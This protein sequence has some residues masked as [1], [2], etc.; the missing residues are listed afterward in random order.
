MHLIESMQLL[1]ARVVKSTHNL[2][3]GKKMTF[4]KV[5]V[6]IEI[7]YLSKKKVKVLHCT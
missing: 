1:L 3:L 4:V 6:L 5:K 2:Y 7:F